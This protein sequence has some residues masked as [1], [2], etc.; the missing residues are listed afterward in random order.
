VTAVLDASAILALLRDEPG[1]HR[2]HEVIEGS[3]LPTAN[4]A[5]VLAKHHDWGLGEAPVVS[6]LRDLGCT[7]VPITVDDARVQTLVRAADRGG[8]PAGRLSLADRLCL[9]VAI[10][11]DLPALTADR[12]WAELDL[13]VDVQVIR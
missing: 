11:L 4:L 6:E 1:A 7:F 5:E 8:H 9:A 2:V 12:A 13:G 3:Q 10:R